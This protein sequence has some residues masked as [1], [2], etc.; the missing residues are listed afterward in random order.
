M[1]ERHG[2]HC[3]EYAD[4]LARMEATNTQMFAWLVFCFVM[5]LAGAV[6]TVW[7]VTTR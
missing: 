7:A 1:S 5:A 2:V 4:L 6:A 3:Q